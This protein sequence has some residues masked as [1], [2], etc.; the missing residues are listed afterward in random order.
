[1]KTDVTEALDQAGI[2]YTVKEHAEP[3]LTCETAAEQRGV[4]V[5]QIVKCMVGE[6]DGHQLVVM[7]IPGD[8]TLKASKARKRLKAVSLNLVSPPGWRQT[9]A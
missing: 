8:R 3:A 1:M 6:S 5:S 7:L 9:S 2:N 4:R